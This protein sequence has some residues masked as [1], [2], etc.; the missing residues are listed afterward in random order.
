MKKLNKGLVELIHHKINSLTTCLELMEPGC[1]MASIDLSNAFH[2]IPMHPEL[3]KY[4]KFKVGTKIYR[5]LVL[6]MGFRDSPR[7][8]CKI[9]KPVLAYLRNQNLLSS[10]YID[11][12]FLLG[13]STISCRHNVQ[14]TLNTLR[15]LGFEISDK[16]V[17]EPQQQMLHLGFILDSINMSVSLGEDKQNHIIRLAHGVLEKTHISVRLLSQFIGTIVT[18]FPAVDYG[19]LFYK[20]LELQKIECLRLKYDYE[21]LI[22]LNAE[23]RKEINW[24]I[25]EGVF[26]G[27]V[28]SRGNPDHIMQTDSSDFAWGKN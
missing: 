6:P 12:F 26:R 13:H 9:L 21:Q 1:F 4:L 3:M 25:E 15:A 8:F 23:S 16:S 27:N 11:D 14:T 19:Q 22:E 5:Y 20:Q 18:S 17:L 24:W 28:I 7:L 2:T 10:V